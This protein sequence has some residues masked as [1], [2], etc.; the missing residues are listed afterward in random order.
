[1]ARKKKRKKEKG[2]GLYIESWEY[3]IESRNYVYAAAVLFFVSSLIGYVF[4]QDFVFIDKLLENL[5]SQIEGLNARGLILFIFQN[6]LQ[7]AFL[8]FIFGLALGIF[9]IFNAITNGVVLGYVVSRVSETAGFNILLNLLPHGIF[10]LP[11]IFI[12]LGLGMKWGMFVLSKEKLREFKRRF[13][14]GAIVFLTI[15][16]P[17]LMI[18]AVIEG[19]L[20]SFSG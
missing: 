9:P 4:W 5:V 12:A 8:A 20:I 18:G 2:K 16:I 1:M 6:N 7:S 13:L 14:K 11:A 17:L 19:L 10:E 15:V 3:V